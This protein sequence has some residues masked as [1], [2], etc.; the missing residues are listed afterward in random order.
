MVRMVGLLL[1]L[2]AGAGCATLPL[3][4]RMA[5]NVPHEASDIEFIADGDVL[6]LFARSQGVARA[7]CAS[8]GGD[9]AR[10]EGRGMARAEGRRTGMGRVNGCYADARTVVMCLEG[11]CPADVSRAFPERDDF[12]LTFAGGNLVLVSSDVRAVGSACGD[13]RTVCQRPAF[14][15]IVCQAADDACIAHEERHHRER[16]FHE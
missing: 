8:I 16:Q 11:F 6:Y 13:D 14:A 9:V 3:S 1:A 10:Q 7:L 2:F 12:A 15:I 4:A 5:G